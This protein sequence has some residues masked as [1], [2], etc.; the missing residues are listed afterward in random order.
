MHFYSSV[1]KIKKS[2]GWTSKWKIEDGIDETIKW[3]KNNR[4]IWIKHRN[5]W[6]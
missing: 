2:I 5:I 1:E 6:E 3:W 4:D